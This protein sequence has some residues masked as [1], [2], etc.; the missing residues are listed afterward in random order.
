MV[1]ELVG[2]GIELGV[3]EALSVEAGGDILRMGLGDA[4]DALG[5][6][7]GDVVVLGYSGEIRAEQGAAFGIMDEAQLPDGFAGVVQGVF[8][9][10]EVVGGEAVES[11]LVEEVA[12]VFKQEAGLVVVPGDGGA[13]VEF[14]AGQVEDDRLD[15][16]ASGK[17]GESCRGGRVSTVKVVS[18]TA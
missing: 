11:G 9:E 2:A 17:R 6:G 10:V 5:K 14:G 13:E 8:E 18:K 4:F 12:V 15:G 7:L 1:G 3:S 16:E